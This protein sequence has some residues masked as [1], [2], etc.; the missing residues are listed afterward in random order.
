M[1]QECILY[2]FQVTTQ[3]VK[4]TFTQGLTVFKNWGAL[5]GL[6]RPFLSETVLVCLYLESMA[7]N[8]IMTKLVHIPATA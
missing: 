8:K 4:K 2:A 7:M 1:Q 3:N 6:L 5:G